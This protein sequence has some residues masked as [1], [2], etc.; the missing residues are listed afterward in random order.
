MIPKQRLDALPIAIICGFLAAC[1]VPSIA[2]PTEFRPGHFAWKLYGEG[3]S[4]AGNGFVHA[5]KK[6]ATADLKDAGADNFVLTGNILLADENSSFTLFAGIGPVKPGGS[7]LPTA[8]VIWDAKRRQYIIGNKPIAAEDFS[9]PTKT[10]IPFT[11]TVLQENG[12]D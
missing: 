4:L 7:P 5:G 8:R 9:E 2:R 12:R 11:V 1:I 6:S 3:G 10:P